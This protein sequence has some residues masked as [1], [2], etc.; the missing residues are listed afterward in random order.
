MDVGHVS[1]KHYLLTF[2]LVF[3]A[4]TF[5]LVFALCAAIDRRLFSNSAIIGVAGGVV[6]T[7]MPIA[8]GTFIAIYYT[9]RPPR[10]PN[11]PRIEHLRI[12]GK[13]APTSASKIGVSPLYLR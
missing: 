7:W 4:V 12:A 13:Y 9:R 6:A 5:A 2:A 1:R 11:Y 3:A 10:Q 8:V